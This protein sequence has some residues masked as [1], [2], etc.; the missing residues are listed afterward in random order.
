MS[1]PAPRA[2]WLLAGPALLVGLAT[3]G[4]VAAVAPAAPAT[5]RSR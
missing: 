4:T 1:R 5:V 2:R 3:V